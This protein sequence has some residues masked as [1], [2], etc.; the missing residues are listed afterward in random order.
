M[1]S[2]RDFLVK[3]AKGVLIAVFVSTLSSC[4]RL[5]KQKEAESPFIQ[6][7]ETKERVTEPKT[8]ETPKS[9]V[10]PK[11][12]IVAVKGK[13]VSEIVRAAIDKI[14]GIA[15]F[16]KRGNKVLIKPNILYGQRPEYAATTN[17]EIIATLVALCREAGAA[18]VVVADRPTSPAA[19]AYRTSG[20]AEATQ[21]AG[22]NIKILT[23]R[24]FTSVA[25]SQG[26]ILKKAAILRDLFESDVFI[27]VPIAKTHS[28][29]VLTL[30]MKNMM[31]TMGGFRSPMHINFDQK[32]VDL[33]TVIKPHMVVLDAYH[34]LVRN[35]PTGGSLSDVEKPETVVVGTNPVSVDAYA[36][37]FF[38]MEPSDLEYLILANQQGLG[39]IDLGKLQIEEINV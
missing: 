23:D 32:I 35:G 12:D 14:G 19:E 5:I 15:S 28:L 22:G 37:G 33:N 36:T 3:T 4:A 21:R 10:V 29:A 13:D 9:K 16:V 6:I 18:R 30:A 38:D 8:E 27:N 34:I 20:I 11:P 31:G 25:I 7:D 39:E 2:R 26:K 17:P 24:N 1:L